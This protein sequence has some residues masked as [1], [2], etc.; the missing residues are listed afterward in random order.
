VTC[1]RCGSRDVVRVVYG[2][3]TPELFEAAD[4]GRVILGGCDP[5]RW[6]THA[7]RSCGFGLSR[8]VVP[9]ES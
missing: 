2:L 9:G 1:P 6:P 3:P 5:F 7:C 8:T 4:E